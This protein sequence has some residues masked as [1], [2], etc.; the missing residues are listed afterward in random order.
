MDKQVLSQQI[1]SNV[2]QLFYNLPNHTFRSNRNICL[3]RPGL[4]PNISLVT[5][6]I[7]PES[8]ISVPE[9]PSL[10]FSNINWDSPE[11]CPLRIKE[12][13]NN[14]LK[15]LS[16]KNLISLQKQ[17]SW[18]T[19]AAKRNNFFYSE[20]LLFR[21]TQTVQKLVNLWCQINF[22]LN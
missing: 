19:N 6:L 9:T 8:K 5:D 17:E 22:L 2:Q 11:L 14:Y 12:L 7:I 20:G 1:I 3:V 15:D 21:T 13:L 10:A 16:I 18:I 4:S